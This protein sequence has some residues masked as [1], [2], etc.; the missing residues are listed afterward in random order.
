MSRVKQIPNLRTIKALRGQALKIDMGKTLPGTLTAWMKK[1]PTDDTYRSFEVIDNRFLFLSKTKASDYYD[2]VTNKLIESVK[3]RWYFDI[4]NTPIGGNVDQ[5]EIIFTG[6]IL[7]DDHITDSNGVELVNP[8]N[9]PFISTLI[10]L[11]DTPNDYGTEGQVLA[12]NSTNTAVEFK[13]II[14]DKHYTHDQ[15]M[16]SQVWTINHGLNKYPTAAAV[17]SAKSVVM[18]QIDYIDLNNITITFN[19]SF[20]GEAY[21]N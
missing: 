12:M 16:P 18:G 15:G 20:S 11:T 14:E 9:T 3:G 5:E 2:A 1:K 19:A 6:T 21:L 7:F 8:S 13:T 10:H 4:R 17:D